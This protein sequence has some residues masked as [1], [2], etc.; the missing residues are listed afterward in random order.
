MID[1]RQ[2]AWKSGSLAFV[3]ALSLSEN[4]KAQPYNCGSI[5]NPYSGMCVEMLGSSNFTSGISSDMTGT[6]STGV[7]GNSHTLYGVVATASNDNPGGCSS[8][9]PAALCAATDLTNAFGIYVRSASNHA[10]FATTTGG[11]DGVH[12]EVGNSHNAVYASN[13]GSGP[14]VFGF[15]SSGRGV[16]AESTTGD[17]IW[18]TT[19]ANTPGVAAGFFTTSAGSQSTA[20]AAVNNSSGTGV[21]ANTAGGYG[22]Y[23]QDT[24]SGSSGYGVYGTSTNGHGVYGAGS[25]GMYA[26]GATQGS[27]GIYADC[28]GVHGGPC[29]AGYFSGNVNVTGALTV[30]SCSGCTSDARLKKNVKPLDG[31]L[32]QLLRLKGVTFEWIDSTAHESEPDHGV[33]TQRGFIAQDVEKAFPSMVKDGGYT[34]NDGQKYKTLELRQLEALE[35]ESIRELK[36]E[37][38]ALKARVKSLEDDRRPLLSSNANGLGL[39][40]GGFAL[41]GAI[42]MSRRKRSEEAPAS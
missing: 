40:V 12:S 13:G 8:T 19:S 32:D 34:A 9:A 2:W 39:G 25:T 29:N 7:M 22:V 21:Y 18:A 41:A 15:S 33:G 38:D 35:V 16:D 4:A 10:I 20:V 28:N 6:G 24:G 36:A 37:N 5:G 23:G 1:R 14:G 31:A 11:L 17:G 3:A 30:G 26:H 42:I 27:I